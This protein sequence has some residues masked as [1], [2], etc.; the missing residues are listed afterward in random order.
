MLDELPAGFFLATST[1]NQ[2]AAINE[3]RQAALRTL[4]QVEKPGGSLQRYDMNKVVQQ[5]G[6]LVSDLQAW[7]DKLKNCDNPELPS[8]VLSGRRGHYDTLHVYL[9][10]PADPANQ[11]DTPREICAVTLH[12]CDVGDN[13][14][15]F[16]G[17]L[18]AKMYRLLTAAPAF[19]SAFNAFIESLGQDRLDRLNR[20]EKSWVRLME[21]H[22]YLSGA[23]VTVDEQCSSVPSHFFTKE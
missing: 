6:K 9:P 8:R 4:L 10:L 22:H 3:A 17:P 20:N 5:V 2:E 16:E 13:G 18:T 21:V 12:N 19:L 7:A 15:L 14:N 11:S 23:G 1:D